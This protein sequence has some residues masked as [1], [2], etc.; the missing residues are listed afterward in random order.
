MYIPSY[1]GAIVD[2]C[3]NVSTAAA[4]SD[5]NVQMIGD[6]YTYDMGSYGTVSG[7]ICTFERTEEFDASKIKCRITVDN[8]SVDIDCGLANGVATVIR[9][10]WAIDFDNGIKSTMSGSISSRTY[11]GYI[12]HAK[13]LSTS[14][15]TFIYNSKITGNIFGSNAIAFI[16]KSWA[17][18]Q[19]GTGKGSTFVQCNIYMSNL[20]RY[21]NNNSNISIPTPTRLNYCNVYTDNTSFTNRIN[22]GWIF[23]NCNI[24][25][26]DT[27]SGSSVEGCTIY[28]KYDYTDIVYESSVDSLPTLPEGTILG[29][30]FASY[31]SGKT[32][33]FTV[34]L[35]SPVQ[36]RTIIY[37]TDITG[38]ATVNI[39]RAAN[40]QQ[41]GAFGDLRNFN[42]LILNYK[43][44]LASTGTIMAWGNSSRIVINGNATYF[45]PC[46]TGTSYDGSMHGNTSCSTSSAT[47]N[48]I[49]KLNGF[50]GT[51]PY[52]TCTINSKPATR[53]FAS[54]SYGTIFT[55][56]SFTNNATNT[57][58]IKN[59]SITDSI[60]FRCGL[61]GSLPSDLIIDRYGGIHASKTTIT[62]YSID[63]K[64]YDTGDCDYIIIDNSTYVSR[65]NLT[66]ANDV[67]I[68]IKSTNTDVQINFVNK[69][70][71]AT[72]ITETDDKYPLKGVSNCKT[73]KVICNVSGIVYLSKYNMSG[74]YQYFY[75]ID[76]LIFASD[77]AL[78]V[79]SMNSPCSKQPRFLG[80]IRST[81]ET[82]FMGASNDGCSYE[83]SYLTDAYVIQSTGGSVKMSYPDAYNSVYK[84]FTSSIDSNA[85]YI[86]SNFDEII[87]PYAFTQVQ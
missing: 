76:D 62:S 69:I 86:N 35:A 46:F 9:N 80:I 55:A 67:T 40:S 3:S 85:Y 20:V 38:T 64:S 81:N 13:G 63:W 51:I 84:V 65:L 60:F 66:S 2:I 22:D 43:D 44:E 48:S 11:E 30:D 70:N 18:L 42:K 87:K 29:R 1:Y 82:S 79:A 54:S 17:Y 75:D 47:S 31:I 14:S 59:T 32:D 52:Y 36:D 71:S 28:N 45:Y 72:I 23:E 24:Y 56:N 83:K 33:S 5:S 26:S 16:E 61:D 6:S 57:A 34:E 25:L 7:S 41:I 78:A 77:Y 49:M 39:C 4:H 8:V 12:I 15:C 74:Y 19:N 37:G 68:L 21:L 58:T 50:T 10:F 73:V 53:G 27:Y